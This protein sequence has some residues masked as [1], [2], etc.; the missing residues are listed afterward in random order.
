MSD[1]LP[2]LRPEGDF[3]FNS[4]CSMREPRD[5]FAK[6]RHDLERMREDP[7]SSFPVYDF[8]VTANH[9]VDWVWPSLT[10]AQMRRQR[11]SDA[12]LRISEHLGNAAKHF[13][14]SRE[15][16]AVAD[17]EVLER[18]PKDIVEQS[19]ALMAEPALGAVWLIEPDGFYVQLDDAAAR[20]LG[21]NR[22]HVVTLAAQTL[23]YWQRRFGCNAQ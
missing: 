9:M 17:I 18:V 11:A 8:F 5:L 6:L 10:Q 2:R 19:F 20:E 23:D 3:G 4:F 12:Y 7:L 15:H 1:T 22:I 14:L 21:V 13:L 16:Y